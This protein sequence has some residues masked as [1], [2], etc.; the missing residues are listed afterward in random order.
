LT[1]VVNAAENS[2][3]VSNFFPGPQTGRTSINGETI[4]WKWL[5]ATWTMTIDP[6]GKTAKIA[7]DSPFETCRGTLVKKFDY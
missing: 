4:S 3:T 6:D 7:A 5:L 1:V 2:A